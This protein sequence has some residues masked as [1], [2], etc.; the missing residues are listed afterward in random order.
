MRGVLALVPHTT[1]QYE[2]LPLFHIPQTG[3]D[4]A[5]LIAL[6]YL[7]GILIYIR[8]PYDPTDAT[9]TLNAQCLEFLILAYLLALVVLRR[10][11]D[12]PRAWP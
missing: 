5:P 4:F 6:E 10:P 1:A 3:V 7:T 8:T 9:G 2:S 12:Q 11:C